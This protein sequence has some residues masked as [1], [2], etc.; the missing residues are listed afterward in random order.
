MKSVK[1]PLC[2]FEFSTDEMKKGVCAKCPLGKDCNLIC[3]PNC[4]YRFPTESRTVN[5][6]KD[7]FDKIV[8]KGDNDEKTKKNTS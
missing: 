3:C 2:G 7:T 8:K 5:L 6:L 1:C 4:N